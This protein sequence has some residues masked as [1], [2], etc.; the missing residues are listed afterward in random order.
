MRAK[1]AAIALAAGTLGMQP[2]AAAFAAPVVEPGPAVRADLTAQGD[3]LV[4]RLARGVEGHGHLPSR[5]T[6]AVAA[7]DANG[8]EIARLER[9]VSR[10]TLVVSF[11]AEGLADAARLVVI[12]H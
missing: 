3:R 9:T 2:V 6:L 7:F 5:R 10:R 11:D 1:L 8:R 4:V 12:A